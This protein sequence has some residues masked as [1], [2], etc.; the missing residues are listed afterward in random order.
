M[1]KQRG[2]L[3]SC[4]LWCGVAAAAPPTDAS[5]EEMMSVGN[6]HLLLDSVKAQMEGT[7]KGVANQA[8]Q[9]KNLTPERQAIMDRMMEKM[10]A[11]TR[12]TLDWD[13]LKP[14][15]FRVYRQSFTQEDVDGI[16]AFYKTPAGQ[17][18]ISKMPLVMQNMM[19]EMGQ[20]M[21]PMRQKMVEIQ[22]EAIEEMKKTP[23]Q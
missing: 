4:L 6:V 12:D 11:V 13:T 18:M 21:K 7:M 2:I 10:A 16:I 1:N 15:F 9:G 8:L 22:H 5:L 20:M 3:L 19:A 17:A 23:D 14:M